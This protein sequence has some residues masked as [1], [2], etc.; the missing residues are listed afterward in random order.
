M[1]GQFSASLSTVLS[2]LTYRRIEVISDAVDDAGAFAELF[3]SLAYV[4]VC[5]SSCNACGPLI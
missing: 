3:A 5:L 1:N 2:N 4:F